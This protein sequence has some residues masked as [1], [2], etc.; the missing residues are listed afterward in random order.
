VKVNSFLAVAITLGAVAITVR[1][2]T[3]TPQPV[4]L[5][6]KI[7][8]ISMRDAMIATLDGKAAIAQMENT[9]APQRA[10]LEKEGA[11]IQALEEQG[12]KGGATMTPEAVRKLSDEVASRKKKLERDLDDLNTD[13]EALDNRLMQDITGKMGAVIDAYAKKNGFT[14]V[15]DASVPVLWAAES[16]NITPAVVKEYDLAHPKK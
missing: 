16:A 2:Q 6:A 3:A 7:A 12:R 9:I 15:M 13:A 1:S 10:K 14:V 11:A 4:A 5:S 8:V